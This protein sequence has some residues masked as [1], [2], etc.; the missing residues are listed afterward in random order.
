MKKLTI[1]ILFILFT[2][3][4]IAGDHR[5]GGKLDERATNRLSQRELSQPK[6][7]VKVE[8]YGY[9]GNKNIYFLQFDNMRQY[10]KWRRRFGRNKELRVLNQWQV[11]RLRRRR[12][13]D[14]HRKD[15][16]NNPRRYYYRWH[17]NR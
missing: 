3:T 4:A 14:S 11:D 13:I 8:D 16:W 10:R 9:Y 5:Y 7:F 1:M 2:S 17:Y 12:R 6:V 15:R